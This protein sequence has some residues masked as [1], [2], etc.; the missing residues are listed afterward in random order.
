MPPVST[1]LE[2]A[3]RVPAILP[4]PA[5]PEA[6]SLELQALDARERELRSDIAQL[7]DRAAR[8]DREARAIA[9][10]FGD[11][12][13]ELSRGELEELREWRARHE[14]VVRR[15]SRSTSRSRRVGSSITGTA[16]ER[17]LHASSV[18]SQMRPRTRDG[19]SAHA[20]NL[21]TP[22]HDLAD[23]GESL[24]VPERAYTLDSHTDRPSHPLS[25]S[26][27]PDSP[28][29]GLGDRNRSPTPADGW[30]IMR[31][32]IEPDVTLPSEE[33]SFAITAA[34]HSFTDPRVSITDQSTSSENSHRTSAGD[35][36]SDSASSVD[37]EDIE[38]ID[39]EREAT[40][41]FAR[42]MY[43]HETGTAEGMERIARHRD[44][45]AREGC[46]FLLEDE[47]PCVEIGF[48]LIN[49]A[50]NSAEG[51]ERMFEVSQMT[52]P[53]QTAEVFV[54]AGDTAEPGDLRATARA[55]RDRLDEYLHRHNPELLTAASRSGDRNFR[56][57]S[58]PPQ[59]EPLAS[60][61]DVTT[62]TSREAPEAY[63]VGAATVPEGNDANAPAMRR[64]PR[65]QALQDSMQDYQSVR[66]TR[67]I[68]VPDE[69]YSAVGLDRSQTRVRSRSPRLDDTNRVRTGR[70][71]RTGGN[72]RL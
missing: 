63:P 59:Y 8:L 4:L 23:D 57:R 18:P 25:R 13:A 37:P 36:Q 45:N 31:S 3:D 29:S 38:C 43:I 61:P 64:M 49:E 51:R 12:P 2:S 35:N 27:R 58:P 39:D 62:F 26:W 15:L 44:A 11:L 41:A 52:L 70:V 66:L 40:A 60:H 65:L 50:L 1:L 53:V 21:P 5:G 42:D 55:A 32:T 20:G 10:G 30:E 34:N 33:S 24:F 6:R 9:E 67:R 48:R 19:Q 22:P 7:Q 14:R 54:A 56:S 72:S 17:L 28:I 47:P 46:I 16:E 71:E 68:E 69:W